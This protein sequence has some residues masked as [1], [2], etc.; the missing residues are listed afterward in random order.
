MRLASL[1]VASYLY[2]IGG[3]ELFAQ[4]MIVNTT[5]GEQVKIK[6]EEVKNITFDENK[7][8]KTQMPR[9]TVRVT[10]TIY[11]HRNDGSIIRPYK[12]VTAS[13]GN[14]SDMSKWK[15]PA[16]NYSGI[17]WLGDNR[18]AIV[19]D[20]QSADGWQEVTIDLNSKTGNIEKMSYVASHFQTGTAG[21]ARDA[22]GIALFPSASTLFISAESD[23]QVV[24]VDM[25]GIPTGRR[26]N[27]PEDAGISKIYGNYGFEALAYAPSVHRFWTVTENTLKA[28]GAAS[29]Y[30]SNVPARMRVMAF[31]DDMSYLAQ[32]P[33]IT[34]A[35]TVSKEPKLYAFGIPALTALDDGSLLVMEREFYVASSYLGSY[36]RNKLYRTEPLKS[37]PITF[38]DDI[39]AMQPSDFI[40]KTLLA[41]FTTTL[42][43][44]PDI[45]NFE[46]MCLGPKL[47]DGRQTLLLISDSQDNYGNSLYHLK[48][49]IRVVTLT[50]EE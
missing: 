29:G 22:E 3:G 43:G 21:S 7:A 8:F 26:L 30:G 33:Y 37:K 5:K 10:D 20:K 15:I 1:A 36:V 40:P 23:Q 44:S 13:V 42:L 6:T 31:G 24:E 25:N 9:D 19:S 46:G 14:Q 39:K 48:D 41:E 49:Y 11:V 17:A 32:Y 18:Y 47:S 28:D 35:P 2:I 16:G 27:I 4:G 50:I 34:D 45:A 38:A 12:R